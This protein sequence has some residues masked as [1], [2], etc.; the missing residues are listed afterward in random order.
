M[1]AKTLGNRDEMGAC[2]FRS[3][4]KTLTD[5]IKNSSNALIL[6]SMACCDNSREISWVRLMKK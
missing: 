3:S 4:L 2:A 5:S 1:A 6:A